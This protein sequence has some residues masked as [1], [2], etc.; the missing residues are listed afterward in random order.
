MLDEWFLHDPIKLMIFHHQK[1]V[2]ELVLYGSSENIVHF[3]KTIIIGLAI[4]MFFYRD[5]ITLV[6]QFNLSSNYASN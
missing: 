4:S 2:G 3:L 6:S 5:C 1:K